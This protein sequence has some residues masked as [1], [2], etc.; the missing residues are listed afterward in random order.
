MKHFTLISV[1][2]H[3]RWPPSKAVTAAHLNA[4]A[5]SAILSSGPFPSILDESQGKAP[6]REQAGWSQ[7]K[8]RS[9]PRGQPQSF[10]QAFCPSK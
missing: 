3:V 8:V 9:Q 4:A 10:R 5:M 2:V 1:F 7:P 6:T